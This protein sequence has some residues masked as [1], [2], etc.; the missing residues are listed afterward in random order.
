MFLN[1]SDSK[2]YNKNNIIIGVL[3]IILLYILFTH[4]QFNKQEGFTVKNKQ[5]IKLSDTQISNKDKDKK[6]K[7]LTLKQ[8]QVKCNEDDKCIGFSRDNIDDELKGN[9]YPSDKINSCHSLYKFD[10][11]W[12]NKIDD[13]EIQWNITIDSL[14]GSSTNMYA[15]FKKQSYMKNVDWELNWD[16][17]SDWVVSSWESEM[18][19]IEK[20]N[21]SFIYQSFYK[22]K[23][24]EPV[25]MSSWDIL[26]TK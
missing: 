22:D 26:D 10:D 13:T 2:D 4:I 18:Y 17:N 12:N 15:K 14:L 20:Y 11:N 19:V 1:N 21:H 23:N 7:N 5:Y 9:C 24:W 25:V 16:Y 6:W 8:C 3:I